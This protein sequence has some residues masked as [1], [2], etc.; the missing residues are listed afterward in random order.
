MVILECNQIFGLDYYH[1]FAPVVKFTTI[2]TLL[3]LVAV[4]DW[5]CEQMDVVTAFLNGDL[6]EDIYMHI[7]LMK[8][9][10]GVDV[11]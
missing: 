5:E 6:D 8:E 2:R 11:L 7:L 10:V 9:R 1:T 3:A 4:K